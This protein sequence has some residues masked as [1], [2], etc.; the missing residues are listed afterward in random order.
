MDLIVLC[1]PANFSANK[2][3]AE[4]ENANAIK[5]LPAMIAVSVFV[6]ETVTATVYATKQPT[7]VCAC[8]P[9]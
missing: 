2:V 3:L 5:V 7:F 6:P 4:M 1:L 8:L 9:G